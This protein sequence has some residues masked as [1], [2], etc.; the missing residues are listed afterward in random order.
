MIIT[1]LMIAAGIILPIIFHAAGGPTAGR[2]FLPMHIPVLLCG[3]ICGWQFGLACGVIT[4]LLS[5]LMT[6]MPMMAMLPGMICELAVYGAVAGILTHF[7]R[8][9]GIYVSTFISLAGA[10]I[11]GRLVL[12][13]LNSLIFQAGEYSLQAWV[14]ASF[15]TALPGIAI[16][17]VFIPAIVI[18]LK[19]A[20][21]R[22]V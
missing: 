4:P 1:A 7:I 2:T 19:K 20:K 17:I 13:V 18:A 22:L 12:G 14:T 15:V 10:M 21:P 8:A 5:A 3:L 11:S 16:Q 9:K 6:G